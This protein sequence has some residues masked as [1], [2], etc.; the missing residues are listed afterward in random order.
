MLRRKEC[1]EKG[2]ENHFVLCLALEFG[3][4]EQRLKEVS[5]RTGA[6]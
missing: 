4:T 1:G 5:P 6:R 2:L 3:L